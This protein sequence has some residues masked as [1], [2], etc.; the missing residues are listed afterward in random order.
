MRKIISFQK[1]SH[2]KHQQQFKSQIFKQR[3]PLLNS[4]FIHTYF[5][6][7]NTL[8]SIYIA[9]MGSLF[10]NDNIQMLYAFQSWMQLL[11][12]SFTKPNTNCELSIKRVSGAWR[13]DVHLWGSYLHCNIS[14]QMMRIFFLRLCYVKY[15]INLQVLKPNIYLTLLIVS[16]W[17]LHYLQLFTTSISNNKQAASKLWIKD[18]VAK[19]CYCMWIN[20]PCFLQCNSKL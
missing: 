2:H 1:F 18:F 13:Y 7:A 15:L 19:N 20:D 6:Q 5:I 14:R 3:Q 16:I 8:V 9:V 4:T 17:Y 10:H 11:T 12:F